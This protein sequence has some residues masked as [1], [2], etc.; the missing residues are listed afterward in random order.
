MEN[1][2]NIAGQIAAVWAKTENLDPDLSELRLQSSFDTG[3]AE[4]SGWQPP[5][6][7]TPKPASFFNIQVEGGG[8]PN[9][10]GSIQFILPG[11]ESRWRGNKDK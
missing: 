3:K 1:T 6:P 8:L 9:G 10:G 11:S 2:L 7:G 4:W 5:E